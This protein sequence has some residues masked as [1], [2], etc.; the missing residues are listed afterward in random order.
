VAEGYRSSLDFPI[1]Q[2]CFVSLS[3]LSQIAIKQPKSIDLQS[4]IVVGQPSEGRHC[5]ICPEA[6]FD[7]AD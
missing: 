5:H 3:H 4:A 7:Y 2:G 6:A 1:A